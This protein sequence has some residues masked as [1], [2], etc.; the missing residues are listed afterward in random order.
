MVITSA[1]SRPLQS[2]SDF[3]EMVEGLE[4]GEVIK[5]DVL[6]G[7]REFTVFLRAPE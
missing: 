7:R 5:L 3:A 6:A 2:V 1:N 4:P